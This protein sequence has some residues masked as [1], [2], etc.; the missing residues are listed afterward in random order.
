ME[1]KP[2]ATQEAVNTACDLLYTD[3]QTVTVNAVIGLTGGSFSTVGPMVKHW[4][5]EQATQV[6][7]LP[8]IP[9]SVTKSMYKAT[10]DIWAAASTLASEAIERIQNEASEAI[11]KAKAELQEYTGEVSRLENELKQAQ[12]VATETNTRL[13]D[14]L[15]QI[16]SFTTEKTALETRLSDRNEEMK[17]IRGDYEKLQAELLDIAKQ[18]VKAAQ[19]DKK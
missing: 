15:G 1:R 13:D 5:E 4:K 11:N 10:A 19:G 2:K 14:A 6:A 16:S 18:K 17:R 9:E 7:P 3:N 8:E 12:Q